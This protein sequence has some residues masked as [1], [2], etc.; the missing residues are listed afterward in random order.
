M[1]ESKIILDSVCYTKVLGIS[2][3]HRDNY[4]KEINYEA[5]DNTE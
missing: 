3:A 2:Y 5:L 1:K 4:I